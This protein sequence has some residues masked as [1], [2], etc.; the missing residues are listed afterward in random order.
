LRTQVQK[1]LPDHMV[2]AVYVVLDALPLT[3]NGKLDRAALPAPAHARPYVAPR[4]PLEMEMVRTWQ[5]LLR[6][7]QIGVYDNFFEL[8]GH[9]LLA[10][11]FLARLRSSLQVSIPIRSFFKTPTIAAM[12]AM[13]EE[14][15]LAEP[16]V[17]ET[18]LR[19]ECNDV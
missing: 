19:E 15:L 10:A 5:E 12:A 11:R 1:K 8:G 4:D 18:A 2:P 3:P 9:S 14:I 17:P 6:K 7:E 16:A 13:I